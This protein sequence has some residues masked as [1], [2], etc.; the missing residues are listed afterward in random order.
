MTETQLKQNVLTMIH[1]EFA[2]FVWVYK[3]HDQFTS[4]IPDLLMS[5]NGRFLAVELKRD[6]RSDA[7]KLQ[8]WTL[9]QIRQAGGEA[10]V[11]RSVGEVREIIT[12]IL[13]AR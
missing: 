13:R 10:H 6:E 5:V 12:R 7:T 2:S 11:S 3:P 8:D 9:M 4:G 1:K